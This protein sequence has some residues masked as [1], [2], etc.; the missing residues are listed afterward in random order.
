[1]N[2]LKAYLQWNVINTASSYLSDTTL[3]HRTFDFYGRT[4]PNERNAT[5]WK[6]AVSA[7]NG[8]L[9]EAVGQMYSEKYFLAAAKERMIKLVETCRKLWENGFKD[10]N[11]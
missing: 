3:L 5:R 6:R 8:V 7:V 4:L 2:V 9:G 10:W 11:G 1:M